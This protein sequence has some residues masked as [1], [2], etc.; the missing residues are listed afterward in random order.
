MDV[1]WGLPKAYLEGLR[2]AVYNVAMANMDA[3]FVYVGREGLGKSTLAGRSC[4]YQAACFAEFLGGSPETYFST[5]SIAYDENQYIDKV[6]NGERQR[7]VWYDEAGMGWYSRKSMSGSNVRLN[8]LLMTCR[9]RNLVHNVCIPNYF[10]LDEDVRNRRL[11]AMCNV[12]GIPIV[13]DSGMVRVHKGFFDFYTDDDL[14][15]IWKN[16]H[17]R[18]V[19]FPQTDF[20]ALRFESYDHADP[21]W[22]EYSEKADSN[23]LGI[24]QELLKRQHEDVAKV[25][26]KRGKAAKKAEADE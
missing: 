6:V 12:Y 21:F 2:A 19:H 3:L 7:V 26:K 18:E 9:H 1:R 8:Q 25:I 17:T 24:G 15:K 10:A 11:V 22:T 20:Q 4:H 13:E 14:H 5:H 16:E 23:K